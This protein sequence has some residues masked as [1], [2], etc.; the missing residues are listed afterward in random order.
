MNYYRQLNRATTEDNIVTTFYE[1]VNKKN[2]MVDDEENKASRE[3]T[4]KWILRILL[5]FIGVM[6]LIVLGH[7]EAVLSPIITNVTI[8]G[9]G[10]KG[11][12]FTHFKVLLV[13]L[14]TII[15]SIMFLVKVFF[16]EGIV[17]PTW[18]NYF[19]SS[20]GI[21]IVIATIFSPTITIALYGQ[22]ERSEGAITW[23][24]YLILIF[25]SMNINYPKK[26]VSHL[27]YVLLPFVYIN[28]LITI[29]SFSGNNILNNNVVNRVLTSTLPSGTSLGENSQLIG[30][31]NQ[32]N[33]MSGMFAIIT[34]FYLTWAVLEKHYLHKIVAFIT[35]CATFAILLI[36]MS[37]NGFLTLVCVLPFILFLA[38]RT[39]KIKLNLA[40]VAAFLLMGSFTLHI[41]SSHNEK[42]WLESVG[43]FLKGVNPYAEVI[44]EPVSYK[45][46]LF[47]DFSLLSKVSASSNEFELPVLP[48]PSWGP[49][50]GRIYIWTE[51]LKLVQDRPLLGYGIDTIIYH[52][53]HYQLEAQGNL[54]EVTI[55][56]KPHNIYLGVL[57]G[58]GVFGFIMFVILCLY[59]FKESI[60]TILKKS[61]L[62]PLAMACIAF[63][64]QA[65]FNDST[66]AIMALFIIFA[67]IL[68]SNSFEENTSV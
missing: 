62:A 40:V 26:V 23:I 45:K 33:Y 12:L 35:S 1:Q 34:A 6:P 44:E 56:D 18:L 14:T 49:G 11:E 16:M 36:A 15:V 31:L 46:D 60:R 29:I 53:P 25:I 50:T 68:I 55:V 59:I 41:L 30:T 22:A 7:T 43:F 54:N 4:D 38:F 17:K 13:I 3:S 8:L 52:F 66:P 61:R 51:T 47:E 5:V 39:F 48:D 58:T 20:L 64:I 37:T 32:W 28:L 67:G 24:C 10:T 65:M 57:F 63:L 27:G 2:T 42:V 19:L 21:F 9:S